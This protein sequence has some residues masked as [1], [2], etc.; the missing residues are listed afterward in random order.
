M[1][2]NKIQLYCVGVGPG[3]PE[4]ITIKAL[5]ILEEAD[6]IAFPHTDRE[7][8]RAVALE[9]ASAACRSIAN[10]EKLPIYVPMKGERG[11]RENA[12][13]A[14]ADKIR[15]ILEGG[16]SVAYI[17][18]GDPMIYGSYAELGN[19][20]RM[21]GYETIYIPGVPSFCAAAARLGMP[22]A[23]GK[24][25]LS[26]IPA[27]G[28]I[29]ALREK[30]TLV[31]MKAGGRMKEWKESGALAGRQVLAVNNCGMEA[32]EIYDGADAIPEETGYFTTVIAR[33][34]E[35]EGER[36][37]Q[38][39]ESMKEKVRCLCCGYKTLEERGAYD[40]CPVC[41]WEDEGGGED[42]L[43]VPSGANHGLTLRQ[44]RANYKEFGASEKEMLKYCRKPRKSEL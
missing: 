41:F 24:E 42:M 23:E 36:R 22:L 16:R 27:T 25:I 19:R 26:I 17:V 2:N 3:D 10:K 4:L 35:L 39:G 14:A 43:D 31:L 12:L 33:Q 44:G 34:T 8:R 11:E 15:E 20:L 7:G 30:E 1:I 9:I 6:V 13:S 32:E 38:A 21:V 37:N 40:I 18:L 28:G 5:R 29:P